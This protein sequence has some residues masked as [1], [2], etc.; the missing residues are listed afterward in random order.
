MIDEKTLLNEI[1][2]KQH[3]DDNA[4]GMLHFDKDYMTIYNARRAAR[5]E[6]V[7]IIENMNKE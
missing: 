1:H 4:I 5:K 6:I 7:E 2:K 3:N